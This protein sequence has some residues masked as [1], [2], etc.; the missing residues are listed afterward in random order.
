MEAWKIALIAIA[1]I[2]VLLAVYLFYR[3]KRKVS[4]PSDEGLERDYQSNEKMDLSEDAR[5]MS[6]NTL[7][8]SSIGQ[9]SISE[10]VEG[11]SET[12]SLRPE[13]KEN[14]MRVAIEKFTTSGSDELPLDI[15]D[16]VYCLKEFDDG[17]A[18]GCNPITQEQ[19]VFPLMLTRA[20]NDDSVDIFDKKLSFIRK[21]SIRM[22]SRSSL[23]SG[24]S[25]ESIGVNPFRGNGF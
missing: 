22:S 4:T 17:W 25:I 15:G 8:L 10:S 16:L 6:R 18:L 23:A 21:P 5:R 19:G 24:Y 13:V 7:S 2:I 3:S 9:L 12:Y 1:G 11:Y 20:K 14:Y